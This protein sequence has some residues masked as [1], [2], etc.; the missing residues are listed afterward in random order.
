MRPQNSNRKRGF[1][2]LELLG[3]CSIMVVLANI[4][5]VQF[6]TTFR[7]HRLS[8]LA[9]D[10]CEQVEEAGERFRRATREA[11]GVVEAV[12][13]FRTGTNLVVLALPTPTDEPSDRRFA[14][15][16]A[17]FEPDRFSVLIVRESSGSFEVETAY[18][19]HLPFEEIEFAI[20]AEKNY[21]STL[22]TLNLSIDTEGTK[23]TLPV[24][25][26]FMAAL[27]STAP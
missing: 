25:N 21:A 14:V 15:L 11:N 9:L 23:S 16:G 3:A 4:L 22:L 27:R 8:Q 5:T 13:P 24:K 7:L 1:T 6:V 17:V 10:R 20:E 26:S 19:T 2:L 18:T 12:G